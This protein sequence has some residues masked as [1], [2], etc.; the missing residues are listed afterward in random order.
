MKPILFVLMTFCATVL[1]LG[2]IQVGVWTDK[3]SYHYGDTIAITITAYNP[4]ADTIVL[5]FSSTCQASFIIDKFNR[6]QFTPCGQTFTSRIIP[7]YGIVNWNDFKYPSKGSG[8]P[9]L[10]T[11]AHVV[12][13][14]VVEQATSDTLLILV[15][16]TTSVT[17]KGL[18]E[19]RFQLAQNYPNPF[20]GMTTISFMLSIAGRVDVTLYN[21]L[22]Q[23]IRQLLNDYRSAGTYTIRADLNDFPSGVYWCRLQVGQRSQTTKLILAK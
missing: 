22:G 21:S 6:A 23:R 3:P 8:W 18:T 2:Q 4:T 19:N 9:L 5:Q 15:T 11:G 13:G 10:S 7:P 17:D 14:Q 1:A 16:P 12:L 20:N